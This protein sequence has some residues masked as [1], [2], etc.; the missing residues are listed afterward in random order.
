MQLHRNRWLS[1]FRIEQEPSLFP[2]SSSANAAHSPL[3]AKNREAR[4]AT[5]RQDPQGNKHQDPTME[6]PF[7][8]KSQLTRHDVTTPP[9]KDGGAS[10]QP[11]TQRDVINN[12]LL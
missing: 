12:A 5:G 3:A 2:W 10:K 6:C 9:E 8:P 4:S 1:E 11:T 7:L